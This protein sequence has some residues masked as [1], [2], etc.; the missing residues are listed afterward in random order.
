VR[1]RTSHEVGT[2]ATSSSNV[3]DDAVW[4]SMTSSAADRDA[5]PGSWAST[6]PNRTTRVTQRGD[7]STE[8]NTITTF[9]DG[10]VLDDHVLTVQTKGGIKTLF[11]IFSRRHVITNKVGP[12]VSTKGRTKIIDDGKQI[13]W[14]LTFTDTAGLLTNEEGATTLDPDGTGSQKVTT[15][16]HDGSG[17]S[18]RYEWSALDGAVGQV[19]TFGADGAT[20]KTTD[21]SFSSSDGGGPWVDE[22]AHQ[23]ASDDGSQW[24]TIPPP[25]GPRGPVIGGDLIDEPG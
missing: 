17:K 13:T 14:R 16:Y 11:C 25:H 10:Q 5:T 23:D 4:A 8:T 9:A 15:T 18:E 12:S 6:G 20:I 1:I 19:E 2:S 7:G 22:N 3:T 21:S 24:D